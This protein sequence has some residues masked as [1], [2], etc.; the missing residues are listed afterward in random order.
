MDLHE[1]AER[2]EVHRRADSVGCRRDSRQHE[3]LAAQ[4]LR[5]LSD[6]KVGS[7]PENFRKSSNELRGLLAQKG[8]VGHACPLNDER[9]EHA[10]ELTHDLAEIDRTERPATRRVEGLERAAQSFGLG[11][12]RAKMSGDASQRGRQDAATGDI[13]DLVAAA[14]CEQPDAGPL[15][16]HELR[17]RPI[18]NDLGRWLDGLDRRLGEGWIAC[19][20]AQDSAAFLDEL[21]DVRERDERAPAASIGVLT[22]NQLVDWRGCFEMWQGSHPC[23]A[24]Q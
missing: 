9:D 6:M 19:H 7:D 16:H 22:M 21:V 5:S 4:D 14:L 2:R 18:R 12:S 13:D 3:G 1:G 10:R 23:L 17:T 24:R 20:G 15:S 8:H 11:N